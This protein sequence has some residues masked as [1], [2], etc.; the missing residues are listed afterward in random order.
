MIVSASDR[1][2]DQVHHAAVVEHLD[3][4]VLGW[5]LGLEADR[6]QFLQGAFLVLLADE[7]VHVVVAGMPAVGVHRE[8]A[9]ERERD[10][11]LLQHGG[12]ALERGGKAL[13]HPMRHGA[14]PSG[15]VTLV[16]R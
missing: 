15:S 1:P 11:G 3:Q 5:L 14:S 4:P 12:H 13:V 2:V 7:E 9:A 16:C 10:V 8:T 6:G